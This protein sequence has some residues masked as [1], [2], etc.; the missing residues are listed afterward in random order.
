MLTIIE[1]SNDGETID[2]MTVLKSISSIE[3]HRDYVSITM[4]NGKVYEYDMCFGLLDLTMAQAAMNSVNIGI[5]TCG[6][7]YFMDN[8]NGWSYPG[9][10]SR[11]KEVMLNTDAD[12]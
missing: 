4:D 9:F 5:V 10:V 7:E 12:D 6:D 1:L 2:N 11:A 3:S 8:L